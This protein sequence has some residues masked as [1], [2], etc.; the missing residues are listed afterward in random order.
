MRTK[1]TAQTQKGLKDLPFRSLL[2]LSYPVCFKK[3]KNPLVL[4]AVMIVTTVMQQRKKR[5]L[6]RDDLQDHPLY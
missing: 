2:G 1:T 5:H 6:R 4:P 3:T